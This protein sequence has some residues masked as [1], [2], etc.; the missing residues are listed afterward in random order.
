ME[1][2][3]PVL[4]GS[5]RDIL[6]QCRKDYPEDEITKEILRVDK[7]MQFYLKNKDSVPEIAPVFEAELKKSLKNEVIMLSG[8]FGDDFEISFLP[9]DREPIYNENGDWSRSNRQTGKP[10]RIFQKLISKEFK[11]RDWEI[12]V[13][14]FKATKCCS[15]NFEIVSGEDIRHYYNTETYFRVDGTLG[16]SCMRYPE[17]SRNFDIYVDHAKMLISTKDGRLTGRALLWEIGDITLMDRIYT[18]YDYL[19]NCFREHAKENKWWIRDD[20]SLLNNGD[21]Q[22]WLSPD[23]NYNVAR[24]DEFR[25]ELNKHYDYFPYID[26]FRYYDGDK[27]LSTN[28]VFD[29]FCSCTDGSYEASDNYME[30]Y[31]CGQSFYGSYDGDVPDELHYSEWADAYYCDDCC[32]WCEYLEDYIPNSED[33]VRAYIDKDVSETVPQSWAE[34]NGYEEIDGVWYNPD[35]F[36]F[37]TNPDTGDKELIK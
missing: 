29:N 28:C 11:Q 20:N 25:I 8:R 2:Y 23:D 6:T 27:T 35:V 24:K 30:C 10:G 7:L 14:R 9:A 33:G 13:N 15:V 3:L 32:W 26:S 36:E 1:K 19:E 16:N 37:R 12:F 21:N 4:S 31:C 34:D 18:C 22:Y 17:C 5:L